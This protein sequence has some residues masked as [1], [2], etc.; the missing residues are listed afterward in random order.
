MIIFRFDSSKAV[1]QDIRLQGFFRNIIQKKE[2]LGKIT[3]KFVIKYLLKR[4]CKVLQDSTISLR[5]CKFCMFLQDSA[6]FFKILQDPAR[7]FARFCKQ[8]E[9]VSLFKKTKTLQKIFG[10]FHIAQFYNNSAIYITLATSK[11]TDIKYF[12]IILQDFSRICRSQQNFLK[13]YKVLQV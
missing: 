13:F 4:S 11:Q 12:C 6:R 3:F 10:T 2:F 9:V 7:L 5:F 1:I 8:A